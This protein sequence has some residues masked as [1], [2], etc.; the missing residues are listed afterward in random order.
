MTDKNNEIRKLFEERGCKVLTDDT[1]LTYNSKVPYVCK[2]GVE[3]RNKTVKDFKRRGCRTCNSTMFKIKPIPSKVIKSEPVTETQVSEQ[4]EDVLT[5]PNGEKEE[6][7]PVV[8]GWISSFGRAKNPKEVLLKLCP[9]KFRYRIAGKHQY[10]SRLVAEAFKLKDYEKITSQS[11]VV[12]HINGDPTNNCVDNLRVITKAEIGVKNGSKSHSS[13]AFNEKSTWDKNKFKDIEYR[14]IDILPN[15][16]IYKN[17]E[18]W[19]GNRFL[20]FSKSEKYL[21]LCLKSDEVYKVHRLVCYAFNPLGNLSFQD[22][23]LLQ[24]NHKDGNTL[25]NH[26]D[27]LEWV[28]QEGNMSHA[29]NNGLNKKV[30]SVAQFDKD[31]HAFIAK[32]PSISKACQATGEPEHRIS[33]IASGGSNSKAKFFW[34][35]CDKDYYYVKD[36]DETVAVSFENAPTD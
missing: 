10:A 36:G 16:K 25:N 35:F 7:R 18:I 32:Y 1:N 26:A 19:N 17:G 2:C 13:H 14:V 6:W 31:T 21:S 28:T 24:V 29:Y 22:Y 12:T 30:K 34:A 3:K 23:N 15:H 8:G 33:S 27:N 5:G 4:D 9:V 20:S 11:Y